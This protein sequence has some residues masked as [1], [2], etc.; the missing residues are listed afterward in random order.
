MKQCA[1][2]LAALLAI[3]PNLL[4]DD[5]HGK[6]GKKGEHEGQQ[7]GNVQNQHNDD[8]NNNENQNGDNEDRVKVVNTDRAVRINND[9]NRLE[10]IL[11]TAQNAPAN[12][13]LNRTATEA[14]ILA[15][16]ILNNVRTT[17]KG[18]PDA[19]NAAKQLRMH[20]REMRKAAAS[21]NVV[22]VKMHAREA[23]PFA[24]RID[25]FV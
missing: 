3:A 21:G 20:V 18:R 13:S 25:G 4:A 12:L 2:L 5:D 19:L 14:D 7:H 16:R 17:L 22:S 24:L 11:A 9:V 10:S 15:N 6:K 8:Q 23:L 1:L